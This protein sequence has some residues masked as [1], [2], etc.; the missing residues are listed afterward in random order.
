M[1]ILKKDEIGRLLQHV[2]DC[3]QEGYFEVPETSAR[4]L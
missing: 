1:T 4:S 2:T 3:E